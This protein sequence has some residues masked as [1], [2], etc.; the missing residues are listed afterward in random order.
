[1]ETLK[2]SALRRQAEDA[3]QA[4]SYDPRRLVLIHTAVSLGSSLLVAVLNFILAQKIAD[5]SGLAG[6]GVQTILATVQG[7]LEA[8]VMLALPF[9]NISLVFA[10]LQWNRREN[11]EP[12]CLLQGFRRLGAVLGIKFI[13]VM[14]YFAIGMALFY[15]SMAIFMLT[16]FSQPM[17]DLLEPHITEGMTQEELLAL[18][19]PELVAEAAQYC[20]PLLVIFGVLFIVA[21]IPVF[22]RLRFADFAVMDDTNAISSVAKSF[23]MTRRN[24]LRLIRLDLHFWW[25]YLLQFLS[26]ALCYGDVIL[27]M[28]GVTLP[29]SQDAAFF[30]FYVLG[31]LFQGLLLWAAQATVSATYAEAYRA[32]DLTPP[33]PKAPAPNPLWEN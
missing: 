33:K 30:L 5:T 25:F 7:V 12:S 27:P 11:A 18:I 15:V 24:T 20:V 17:M 3:L 6:M 19:T 9:W 14:V 31:I 16:P 21:A 22:Y 26:V 1:M 28:F 2:P 32:L 8:V 13:T 23:L 10:A 29:F 4:A